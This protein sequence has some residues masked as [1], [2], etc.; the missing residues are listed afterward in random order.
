MEDIDQA[1]DL[2]QRLNDT[3]LQ[4]QLKKQRFEEQSELFC[5]RCGKDIPE[6]RRKVGGME[7]CIQ[8]AELE[9]KRLRAFR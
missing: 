3:A 8:C 1:Q 6:A 9:E 4:N 5:L 7:H 2:Q